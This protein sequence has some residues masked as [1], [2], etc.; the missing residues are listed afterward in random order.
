M[1]KI[2]LI[3]PLWADRVVSMEVSSAITDDLILYDQEPEKHP[4]FHIS[5]E[6]CLILKL[7]HTDFDTVAMVV[8]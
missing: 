1:K 7:K 6:D 3:S 4:H 8:E 5:E 2:L